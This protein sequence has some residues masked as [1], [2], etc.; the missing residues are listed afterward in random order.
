[1]WLST[2]DCHVKRLEF[3]TCISAIGSVTTWNQ[4]SET[5]SLS[6]FS[7][8][9][10][11]LCLPTDFMRVIQKPLMQDCHV[12]HCDIEL[13]L[14]LYYVKHQWDF[15]RTFDNY[16]KY[17]RRDDHKKLPEHVKLC[18]Y[19]PHL[20]YSSTHQDCFFLFTFCDSFFITISSVLIFN[21]FSII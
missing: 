4:T 15:A 13:Y 3:A 6:F 7:I 5:K 12:T 16:W 1:M 9:V 8:I 20:V 2:A 21:Q 19:F 18:V 17:W 11:L 10:A 14:G